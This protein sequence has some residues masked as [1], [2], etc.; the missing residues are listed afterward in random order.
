VGNF[1]FTFTPLLR[2]Q[3]VM[4]WAVAWPRLLLFHLCSFQDDWTEG[5]ECFRIVM[6]SIHYV[7]CFP[8]LGESV[9]TVWGHVMLG[10]WLQDLCPYDTACLYHNLITGLW[11]SHI[12]MGHACIVCSGIQCDFLLRESAR[13]AIADVAVVAQV[14]VRSLDVVTSNWCTMAK[15]TLDWSAV[16]TCVCVN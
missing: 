16:V 8:S 10:I 1:T 9:D 14:E 12:A 3:Q 4:T 7:N 11:I 2:G 15:N 13:T 6:L 5:S